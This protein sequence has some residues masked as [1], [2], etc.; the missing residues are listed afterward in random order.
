MS[1]KFSIIPL[2]QLLE[3]IL[4]QLE[5][6]RIFSIPEEQFFKPRSDDPFR[7][8]R[9]GRLLETPIG[10]A[11]GPHTQLAQN[12]VAA[13]LTG[14]RY[15]EL[16][17]I[18]TLDELNVSKPCIDMQDEGYNCEWSQE[19]KIHQSFDQYLNAWIIIHVLRHRF[20]LPA[21]NGPG[22][23]FNMSAGY[24]YQ[25]IQKEN[26]Q[27]FLDKMSDASTELAAKLESI[28]T[29]YPDV[30]HLNIN[31][32]I[33][34][35][36]TLSTMHG[37][38]PDE[39]GKI[40]L[41]LI[42]ERKLHTT[43]KL[44][45]TLLGKEELHQVL[46]SSGFETR[47]PDSAFEH[48]PKF[49]D[50]VEI[51]REL[52]KAAETN[53]VSFGLKLTNTLES[54]N[55]KD[56]FP[57]DEK[58]MYMSG[59][60][61]HPI[62]VALAEK[63][64]TRFN[65]KLNIS[66]SAGVDAFNVSDVISCGLYP[67]TVCTD[68]LKPG[69]YGRLNQYLEE[70]RN[71]FERSGAGAIDEF[72][73]AKGGKKTPEESTLANLKNYAQAVLVDERYKK[74]D[75][76]DPDIK[77]N[78][79][80]EMFDCIY[81]PCVDTCP[82]NQDI[83]DYMYYTAT[84][85][86]AKAYGVVMKT[87]PF[88][89][90]TGMICDHPCQTKCTLINYTQP[91][92]IREVKRY[93]AENKGKTIDFSVSAKNKSVAIIGAGPSGLS[94]A[95]FLA[96]TGFRVRVYEA[97][98]RP[99][100]MVTGAIPPF[101]LTDVAV[102]T[103][104]R[105]I[106]R[107]GVKINYNTKIDKL[108]FNR[109]RET[110]DF[111]YIAT[112][113]QRALRLEIENI[114][115]KGVLDP[116]EFLFNVKSGRTTSIG[117]HVVI[118]GG[119]NTA[120]DAARTAYRLVGKDGSV[121][122]VYRRK[123]KHMPADTGEIKAVMQEGIKI[124]ELASPVK[125]VPSSPVPA[126][127]VTDQKKQ[128]NK[129]PATEVAGTVF[130]RMKLS[131]KDKSGRPLPEPI[132][133]SEFELKCDTVIPAIGQKLDIDF[134]DP[135]LLKTA[136]GRY[137][138]Q[139]DNVF[140][141][142]DAKRGAST[143]INAIG[144]GRKAAEAIIRKVNLTLPGENI[145]GRK[146]LDINSHL[147]KRARKTFPVHV[148]E[149]SS[150][151]RKSFKLVSRTFTTEEA[152][153]EASRCLLCDEFCSICTTVC[154]NLA[155]HTYETK[156]RTYHLQIVTVSNGNYEINIGRPFAIT[157][158]YQILHIADWCNECGNCT[159][160][161]PTSGAPYKEK[162]HLYLDKEAFLKEKDGYFLERSH[163]NSKKILFVNGKHQSSLTVF[164]DYLLYETETVKIKLDL[165]SYKINEIETDKKDNFEIDLREAFEMHAIMQG[166]QSFYE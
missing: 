123:I 43:I 139:L 148:E 6:G 118:I 49:E 159:T 2:P 51:I 99:G 100:G 45:P 131:D 143:A 128:D 71:S 72:I 27:W 101:R 57:P 44:N 40:G 160:F 65:G 157:Q 102:E 88:P 133:G 127:L 77:T 52:E 165:F 91:V 136:P 1:D 106:E 126:T 125:I 149:L 166:A 141:G 124:I 67:A 111:V 164:N 145:N 114:D 89:S 3:I 47:V 10:V 78:R 59:R 105:Q 115:I 152:F 95:Y 8:F 82:T 138:T 116:L 17:T 20:N 38:P 35:N 56:V 129:S 63:L 79:P 108:L 24:D 83:P 110:D 60:A 109:L 156:I 54:E 86:T 155:F 41:Y 62:S 81:A 53:H 92:L 87:N 150:L 68:I 7:F 31:P 80:L 112:G 97:K 69:G 55:H 5:K 153:R 85:E 107:L 13:W 15:I 137:E 146:P 4:N 29:V 37:C 33:S 16:K 39:I 122:I 14:A 66:F 140:I 26:V 30:V 21:E 25:G 34:D 142:G 94:C 132:P 154:P 93:I 134:A 103:D 120:M 64:Q 58:M 28:K 121:T 144:D 163:G 11:A 147:I 98:P 104:I 19:L 90:T 73:L 130:I 50:I 42:K 135:K 161:C 119:G 23:I 96:K 18:Q 151:E 22:V 9:Y 76:H 48:D 113:A 32:R 36:M 117:N 75:I 61:L 46:S 12:I 74:T 158:K 70:I 162:P 84:G